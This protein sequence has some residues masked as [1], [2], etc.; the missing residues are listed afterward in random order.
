[1]RYLIKARMESEEKRQKDWVPRVMELTAIIHNEKDM[2]KCIKMVVNDFKLNSD[3]RI[4]EARL[5]ADNE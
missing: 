2:Q 1:M 5:M 4:V 3:W